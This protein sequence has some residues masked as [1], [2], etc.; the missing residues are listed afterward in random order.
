MWLHARGGKGCTYHWTSA[1]T[2]S[3][4]EMSQTRGASPPESTRES[5]TAASEARMRALGRKCGGHGCQERGS[6]SSSACAEAGCFL[7]GQRTWPERVRAGAQGR[8]VAGQGSTSPGQGSQCLC[9]EGRRHA[10][11]RR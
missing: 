6:R 1:G 2:M 8:V 5:R 7:S 3:R 4:L 10:H 9:K 11:H